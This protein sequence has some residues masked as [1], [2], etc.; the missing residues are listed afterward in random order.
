M[1][2]PLPH[3]PLCALLVDCAPVLA[4]CFGAW[5]FPS[6]SYSRMMLRM[7]NSNVRA[8]ASRHVL[9]I[10]SVGT[11]CPSFQYIALLGHAAEGFNTTS[12]TFTE[13]QHESYLYTAAV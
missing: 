7:V 11:F 2:W 10:P 9:F 6:Q 1:Q 8:S 13:H 5:S 12:D 4:S 3:V